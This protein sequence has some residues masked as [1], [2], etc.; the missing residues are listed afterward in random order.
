MSTR[1]IYSKLVL[2][3]F[4]GQLASQREPNSSKIAALA[5]YV[6]TFMHLPAKY[7]A[8]WINYWGPWP[9]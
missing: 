7:S 6:G 8:H 1:N 5:I 2:V 9:S 4:T 3:P